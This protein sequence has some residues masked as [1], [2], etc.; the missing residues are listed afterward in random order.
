MADENTTLVQELATREE[1]EESRG[2]GNPH[3]DLIS[4]DLKGRAEWS[5]ILDE[6]QKRRLCERPKKKKKPYSGAPN[7]VEPIVDD[8]VNEKTDQESSMLHNA[9]RVAHFIPLAPD[10]PDEIRAQ[11]EQAFDGY[12]R[13]VVGMGPKVEE[14]LDTKNA[15][16]F[17]V[18]KVHRDQ[19]PLWGEISTFSKRDNKDVIVPTNTKDIQKSE[20]ICDVYRLNIRQ[21]LAKKARDW[22]N[23][24]ELYK[25]VT[26]QETQEDRIAGEQTELTATELL[27]GIDTTGRQNKNWVIWEVYCYADQWVVDQDWTGEI[28]KGDKCVVIFCPLAPM[29]VLNIFPW[30][31]EDQPFSEQEKI[32]VLRQNQE[33]GKE[34]DFSKLVHRGKPRPWPFVQ[35]RYSYRSSY[36]YMARG[37]GHKNMDGQ[38]AASA[39]TNGK[40]TI[41]DYAMNPAIEGDIA[42]PGN[43]KAEP[44]SRL[45][46]GASFADPPQV[47]QAID[48]SLDAIKRDSARREK[49][50]GLDLFSGQ[51]TQRR[52]LQKTATEVESRDAKL[53]VASSASVDR[54]NLPWRV[55]FQ[56]V[57][58]DLGRIGRPIPIISA[59]KYKGVMDTAIFK[60]PFMVVP[61][62]SS[63]T[64]NPSIQFRRSQTAMGFL[65]GVAQAGV[66]IDFQRGTELVMNHLDPDFAAEVVLSPEQAGPQGQPPVYTQ[67]DKIMQA[68]RVLS[69]KVGQNDQEIESALKLADENAGR[70]EEAEQQ[71]EQL[72]EEDREEASAETAAS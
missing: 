11:A 52:Q 1:D 17:S 4:E 6:I 57:W 69:E 13:H 15:L 35:C 36:Y 10:V 29:I 24:S 43:Y 3:F 39:L 49:V 9:P 18:L 42:N 41:L 72:E 47:P 50:A 58:D 44:G 20:R 61:A 33:Q 32:A 2:S 37:I 7:F 51:A 70:L 8:I 38:I 31:D 27:G 46:K 22:R 40:Y 59:K 66:V 71:M 60:I 53:D 19:D 30:R 62:S 16:G 28:A 26:E 55:L 5:N 48:F 63:K 25:T 14:A 68:L 34:T 64:M 56:L 65:L 45:P 67:L 21:L 12:M 23:L 54:F